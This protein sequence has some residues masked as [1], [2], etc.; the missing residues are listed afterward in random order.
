MS[1]EVLSVAIFETL[2]GK[3]E[4]ALATMQALFAALAAGGYSRDRLYHDGVSHYVVV[5]HWKSEEARRAAQED[6][7]VQRCW[8]R[9]AHEIRIVKIYERLDEVGA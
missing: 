1:Q 8:A 5:R 3:E 7:E 2:P 6:P 4:Q 9:L